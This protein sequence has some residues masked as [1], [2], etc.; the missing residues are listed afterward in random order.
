MEKPWKVVVAFLA[1][2]VA[3]AVFG[4]VFALGVN[5]RKQGREVRAMMAQA[6][7]P[8][9]KPTVV[10]TTPPVATNTTPTPTT[11][12]VVKKGA[13]VTLPAVPG[14]IMPQLMRQ[15][16]QR[17][18]LTPGQRE[19]IRPVLAR[20]SEDLIRLRQENLSDT[21]RVTERMYEDISSTL[22]PSQRTEL[23]KMRVQMQ[24]RARAEALKRAE[25]G[26]QRAEH[27]AAEG[28]NRADGEPAP[29]RPKTKGQ[30]QG[31]Q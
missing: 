1:V 25:Q 24:E 28:A 22:T 3:G 15:F 23:E 2:F 21:V 20:A 7:L 18:D 29:A 16:T 8:E 30:K 10:E 9:P 26:K 17:L 14:S 31:S 5:A 13:F 11:P 27:P 6:T 19:R 12:L 4:G